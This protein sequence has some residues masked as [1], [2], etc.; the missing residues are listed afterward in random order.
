MSFDYLLLEKGEI[1]QPSCSN[2]YSTCKMLGFIIWKATA[3]YK[4]FIKVVLEAF[5]TFF[6]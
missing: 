3:Y 1:I 4:V 2:E 5:W 6:P